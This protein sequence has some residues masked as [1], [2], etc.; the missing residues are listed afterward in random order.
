MTENKN[1]QTQNQGEEQL[2]DLVFPPGTPRSIIRDIVTTF[3]V[4]MVERTENLT[5][6]NMDGDAR[7]L[8]AVRGPYALMQEVEV[9]FKKKMMEFIE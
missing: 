5:F 6:A 8:L 4:E 3:D 9:F 7:N 1:E 2:F